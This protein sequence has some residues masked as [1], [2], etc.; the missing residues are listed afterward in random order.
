M[1]K[2]QA[3]RAVRSALANGMLSRPDTCSRC[4]K[5]DT[6]P[7]SGRHTI[8]AHHHV[9]YDRPL[10]IEWLCPLCHRQETPLPEN[11]GTQVFG[12]RN[13][14]AKLTGDQVE[15]IRQSRDGCR[16]LGRRYGVDK[17][18]VQRIRNGTR[19]LSAAPAP[20]DDCEGE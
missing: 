16:V 2:A 18:T 10:E 6:K 8:Q 5:P 1:N 7:T 4:G 13:G 12:E 17:T 20:S 9:G 3:Y 11:M 19:W 14:A 15:V